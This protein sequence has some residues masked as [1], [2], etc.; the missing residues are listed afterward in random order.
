[1]PD[2]YLYQGVRYNFD[3]NK[4]LITAEIDAAKKPIQ[5]LE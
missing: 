2:R 1:M 4:N 3:I 5:A